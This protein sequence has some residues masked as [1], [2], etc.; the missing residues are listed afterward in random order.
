MTNLSGQPGESAEDRRLS[1]IRGDI[2]RLTQ[3]RKAWAI[4]YPN[5]WHPSE[6]INPV[7]GDLPFT[8]VAAWEFI[9]DCFESGAKFEEKEQDD[10][11]GSV[12][13]QMEVDLEGSDKKLFIKVRIAKSGAK[14]FGRSFH[15]S[16][17]PR[18]RVEGD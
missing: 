16:V 8:A 10:P 18:E 6:V 13:Y 14:I 11:P 15:Y 9:A 3:T 17:D 5:R 2:V 7:F 4:D 1:K 12:A